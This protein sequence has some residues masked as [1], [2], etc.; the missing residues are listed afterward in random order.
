VPTE[1]LCTDVYTP[2]ATPYTWPK[3]VPKRELHEVYAEMA[4]NYIRAITA[5]YPFQ[6]RHYLGEPMWLRFCDEWSVSGDFGKAMR[7]I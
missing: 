7:A 2:S 4:V 6:M 5:R 3:E 1:D